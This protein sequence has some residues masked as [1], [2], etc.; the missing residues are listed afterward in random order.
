MYVSSHPLD[1]SNKYIRIPTSEDGDSGPLLR[2]QHGVLYHN[3]S[4]IFHL[5]KRN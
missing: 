2:R 3:R 1:R 5:N 4:S